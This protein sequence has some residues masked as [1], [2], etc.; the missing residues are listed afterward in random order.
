MRNTHTGFEY[1][2]QLHKVSALV[3][4]TKIT[5]HQLI[6]NATSVHNGGVEIPFQVGSLLCFVNDKQVMKHSVSSQQLTFMLSN[7]LPKISFCNDT[8]L[9]N[10]LLRNMS[11][12][13]NVG[14][15]TKFVSETS[16]ITVCSSELD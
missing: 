6:L 12:E 13:F 11:F 15:C 7:Q 16:P 10:E 14:F 3:K 4:V 2:K 8:I 1:S 9:Y 5:N